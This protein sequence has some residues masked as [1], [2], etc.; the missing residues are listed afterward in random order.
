VL[1]APVRPTPDLAALAASPLD[2]PV[3][4]VPTTEQAVRSHNAARGAAEVVALYPDHGQPVLDHPFVVLARDG[5]RRTA[6]QAVLARLQDRLT[7]QILLDAGFRDLAGRAAPGARPLLGV[8]PDVVL[9][10]QVP[11]ATAVRTALRTYT[12]VNAPARVL[13]VLDVSG[14]MAR[15]VPGAG[16]ATR[17]DLARRSAVAGLELYPD[18]TQVGLWA[19]STGLTPT[20]DHVELVPVSPVGARPDGST[21]R[22]RLAAALAATRAGGDTGLHDTALAAVRHVRASWQP[23]HVNLVVLLSDGR[24]DDPTGGLD[25]PTLL[26]TLTAEQ[27]PARPTPVITIAYGPDSDAAAL[28]AISRA[29][30]GASYVAKDAAQIRAV[31]LDAVGQRECRPRCAPEPVG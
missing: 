5:A 18:D 2:R 28:A 4:V 25:L 14:S 22:Q 19:F 26:R 20:T 23:E 27:D 24:N 10:G 29:T 6:A 13:A 8:D 11:T 12:A 15:P 16:G 30:G 7:R 17:L 31:F 3:P 9:P 1:R 21:G